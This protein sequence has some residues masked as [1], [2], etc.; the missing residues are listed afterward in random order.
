MTFEFDPAKSAGNKAKHGLDFIEA[1]E[2]WKGARIR[3]PATTTKGEARYA[4]IGKIKGRHHTVIVT[5]RGTVVRIISARGSSK[6]EIQI[7]EQNKTA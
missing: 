3:I 1:Q 7:Y 4:L 2:L 5:Y 6:N